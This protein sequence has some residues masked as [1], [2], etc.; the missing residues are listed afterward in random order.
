METYHGTSHRHAVFL[1]LLY[2]NSTP[3]KWLYFFLFNLLKEWPESSGL[4]A[5]PFGRLKKG[6][7]AA[8]ASHSLSS[9]TITAQW[10]LKN[11]KFRV[12]E[13]NPEGG[14]LWF[15]SSTFWYWVTDPSDSIFWLTVGGTWVGFLDALAY[16]S[17]HN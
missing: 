1:A 4:P 6:A 8:T 17:T 3:Q 10:N 12:Y 16:P 7:D 5:P 14:L 9:F 13:K 2:P 15:D 11:A